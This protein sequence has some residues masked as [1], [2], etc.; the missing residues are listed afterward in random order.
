MLLQI[1]DTDSQ[2]C[3]WRQDKSQFAPKHIQATLKGGKRL[4]TIDMC[5]IWFDLGLI[6]ISWCKYSGEPSL[7]HMDAN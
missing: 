3:V 5:F 6:C 7:F 4:V 2:I 1:T